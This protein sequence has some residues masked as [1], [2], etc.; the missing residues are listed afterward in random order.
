MRAIERL[1]ELW[2]LPASAVERVSRRDFNINQNI[3]TVMGYF[4]TKEATE[5]DSGR[6][7]VC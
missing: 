4:L 5:F 3:R 7:E 6:K 2:N 1:Y